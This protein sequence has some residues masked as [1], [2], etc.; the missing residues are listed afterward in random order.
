MYGK[1]NE[2]LLYDLLLRVEFEIIVQN[3]VLIFSSKIEVLDSYLETKVM[4]IYI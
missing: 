2:N 1:N 3:S 4:R